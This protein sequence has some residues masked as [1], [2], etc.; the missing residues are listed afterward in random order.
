VKE[1]IYNYLLFLTNNESK[2]KKIWMQDEI[3]F[4]IIF[5]IGLVI[6]ITLGLGS[7]IGG[8][9]LKILGLLHS[10]PVLSDIGSILVESGWIF[11]GVI[12]FIEA[13]DSIRHNRQD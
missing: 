7:W 13:Y 9:I 3:H 11:V 10:N 4:D 6:S 12:F 5:F 2:P 1:K 8:V